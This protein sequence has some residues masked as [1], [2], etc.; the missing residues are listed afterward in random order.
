VMQLSTVIF[1]ILW[2][3]FNVLIFMQGFFNQKNDTELNRLNNP[4]G[5]TVWIS[6]GSANNLHVGTIMI[7]FPIC[8]NLLSHVRSSFINKIVP[9]DSNLFFHRQVG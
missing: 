4:L 5:W 8:R 2:I 6:R 7:F 1:W 3:A 9:V